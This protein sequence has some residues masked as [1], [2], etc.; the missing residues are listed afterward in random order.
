MIKFS[1]RKTEMPSLRFMAGEVC[2]AVRGV[3]IHNLND[4][5]VTRFIFSLI[6]VDRATLRC[7][8]RH[9]GYAAIEDGLNGSSSCRHSCCYA[10]NLRFGSDRNR[11][12]L[13]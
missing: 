9:D 1:S 5:K 3:I 7:G 12:L 11:Q 13:C 8:T 6:S 2:Q 4:D 10:G